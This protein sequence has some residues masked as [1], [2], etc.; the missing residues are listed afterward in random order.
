MR[1]GLGA[2]AA[3]VLAAVL[4]GCGGAIP[5]IA[6]EPRPD[7]VPVDELR[8]AGDGLPGADAPD[9]PVVA[10]NVPDDFEPVAVLR[11][12]EWASLTDDVGTWSGSRV[13]RLEGD[14]SELLA[15]LAEPD[16]APTVGWCTADM[17]IG[18]ELW[19]ADAA[20]RFIRVPYPMAACPKPRAGVLERIEAALALLT[21][22]DETFARGALMES[23]AATAAGCPTT[24]GPF[25][26]IA[27]QVGGPAGA[28]PPSVIGEDRAIPWEPL[29]LPASDEVTG[30]RLCRYTTEEPSTDGKPF[31]LSGG[32]TFQAS[33]DIGAEA[34][35]QVLDLFASAPSA[36]VCDDTATSV[37]FARPRDAIDPT[38]ALTIELDGCGRAAGP[39][40]AIRA[41]PAALLALLQP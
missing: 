18:P 21:V 40:L 17:W 8:C 20:G 34:A 31:V 10:G 13:E 37:V 1:R 7:A 6:A 12:T 15:A 41:A 23:H 4:V 16:E 33:S 29:A 3:V 19:L 22:T 25:L 32:A 2:V 11:C 35:A 27:P 28:E 26:T 30:M 24:I 9:E 5:F 39:D 14:L 36:G 38:V